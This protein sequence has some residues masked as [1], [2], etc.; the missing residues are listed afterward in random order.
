MSPTGEAKPGTV[1]RRAIAHAADPLRKHRQRRY[2]E[3]A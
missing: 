1:R 3:A 2:K